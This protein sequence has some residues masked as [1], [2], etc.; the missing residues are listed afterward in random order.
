MAATNAGAPLCET[1][2]RSCGPAAYRDGCK[3]EG[4]R[5]AERERKAR[6]RAAAKA[7]APPV[8]ARA[9]A[10]R[11][12]REQTATP[13]RRYFSDPERGGRTAPGK[14]VSKAPRKEAPS[15]RPAAESSPSSGGRG[16]PGTDP[17]PRPAGGYFG[18]RIPRA[19]NRD[20]VPTSTQPRPWA[21]GYGVPRQAAADPDG[22]ALVPPRDVTC[23]SCGGR[24]A[25]LW[26]PGGPG[27][28]RLGPR[29]LCIACAQAV[30]STFD[31]IGQGA[32]LRLSERLDYAAPP[33]PGASPYKSA[34]P[35]AG[36][37]A[38]LLA[39]QAGSATSEQAWRELTHTG[40]DP[41]TLAPTAEVSED[42]RPGG[43]PRRRTRAETLRA[44][45]PSYGA[46][47]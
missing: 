39:A 2:G 30:Q 7:A 47:R 40:P 36:N 44:A 35:P 31:T 15:V 12:K 20:R 26:A 9:S 17:A 24:A 32:T 6:N 25:G 11:P 21:G 37:H 41:R 22:A 43:R 23:R 1:R 16:R 18:G 8:P 19:D 33:R 46:D 4:C 10:P 29:L 45:F 5:A 3:G 27:A 34:P 28:E 13:P 38:A 42:R 14:E